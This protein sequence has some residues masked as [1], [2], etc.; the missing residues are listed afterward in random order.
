MNNKAFTLI[1]L[2]IVVSVIGILAAVLIAVINPERQRNRATEVANGEAVRKVATA[3]EAFTSANGSYPANK[4]CNTGAGNDATCSGYLSS[5]PAGVTYVNATS[6]YY[7]KVAS[8]LIPSSYLCY[9]SET[10]KV[11]KNCNSSCTAS[12]DFTCDEGVL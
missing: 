7:V 1:E 4:D 12:K 11:Y 5:W 10:G 9:K 6:S 8:L 2:L 3:V